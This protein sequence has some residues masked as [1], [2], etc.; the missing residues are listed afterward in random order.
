MLR[1]IVRLF[2]EAHDGFPEDAVFQRALRVGI[3]L[4]TATGRHTVTS[5]LEATGWTDRDWTAFYRAFSRDEWDPSVLFDVAKRH[6]LARLPAGI[7]AVVALDDTGLRKTGKHIPGVKYLR[8]PMS[9]PFR[10]N[11]MRGQRFVQLSFS[12]PFAF[13]TLAAARAIPIEF[14][15]APAPVKPRASASEAEHAAYRALCREQSLAHVGA[16]MIR[17]CRADIDRLDRPDR[18]LLVAV[19]GSYTNATVIR[20][21]PPRTVLIGRVRKDLRTFFP[22]THQPALGRKRTYGTAAPTPEQLRGDPNVPWQPIEVYA[23]GAVHQCEV[24]SLGP[25]LWRKTGA[26]QSFRIIVIRPLRYRPSG[27][28][29]L[30]YRQPAYLLC[31]DPSLPLTDAVRAYFSRWDIEVNHRDE[32]QLIGVG[33]AQVRSPKSVGRLPSFAVAMYSFLLLAY[34]LRHG[35]DASEPLAPLPKWRR[36]SASPRVRLTTGEM[37]DH[38]RACRPRNFVEQPNFS[39]F[40]RNVAQSMKCSKSAITLPSALERALN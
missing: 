5:M 11:L 8:D 37:L 26:D 30:L 2:A 14:R 1:T 7:P 32:K 20:Q 17:A 24:K 19:D 39:D 34:G 28:G 9:P 3:G 27:S 16:T 10:M 31:T 12:A 25:V 38:L 18:P 29:K 36:G 6:L 33:Q 40:A 23:S 35:F 21:L 15:H 4:L 22:P 13:D